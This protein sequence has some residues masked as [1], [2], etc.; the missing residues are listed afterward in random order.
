MRIPAKYRDVVAC[1][2]AVVSLAGV[3]VARA[4]CPA[5]GS[6]Q[7]TYK[8][9]AVALP[10]APADALALLTDGC[11]MASPP[12]TAVTA[13]VQLENRAAT[14]QT[15][16]CVLGS[17]KAWDV[18]RVTLPA[19]GYAVLTLMATSWSGDDAG[20]SLTKLTCRDVTTGGGNVW[21]SWTKLLTEALVEVAVPKEPAP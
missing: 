15:V 16:E 5:V 19:G 12:A 11:M 10:A 13:K 1:M 2:V 4:D 20:T 18:S 6:A 7:L 9:V 3:R 14:A 17:A 21:A 8:D